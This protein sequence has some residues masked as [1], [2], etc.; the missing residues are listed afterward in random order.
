MRF[1]EFLIQDWR[2]A[3]P[4]VGENLGDS[5]KRLQHF[6]GAEFTRVSKRTIGILRI[7]WRIVYLPARQDTRI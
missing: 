3:L 4:A 1:D 6:D 2:G 7:S 5:P